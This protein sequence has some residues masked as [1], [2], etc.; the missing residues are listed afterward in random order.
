MGLGRV[1]EI[2][3]E[4]HQ[5]MHAQ[6]EAAT[7]KVAIFAHHRSLAIGKLEKLA[8]RAARYGQSI[9]WTERPFVE[10]IAF[11]DWSGE[12]QT[13]DV[14]RVELSVTGS[15]PKAGEYVFLAQLE[16]M[17]GGVMVSAVTGAEIGQLGYE[18]NGRCDHCGSNRARRVAFVVEGPD[19]RK[20]VGK[21]CLRDHLGTDAPEGLLWQFAQFKELDAASKD[22]EWGGGGY[23][24][25]EST[26]GVIAT[27]RAAIALYGWRPSSHEG[28]TTATYTNLLYSPPSRDSKGRDVHA[29]ERA[30][31]RT[32]LKER[33]DHY[34]AEAE[35]VVDWGRNLTPRGDY[36]HN[37]KVA[38]AGDVVVGKT[39]NLVVSACAAFDRQVAREDEAKRQREAEEAKRASM[40]K[41]NHTGQPGERITHTITVE[42]VIGLPDYGY[43]PST[44]YKLRSDEG[45]VL[46]WKTSSGAPRIDGKPLQQGDRAVVAATVKDH[47]EFRGE[48]ETRVLRAKFTAI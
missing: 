27:A 43:G 41:S 2:F 40:P 9:T 31:L 28:F 36:E 8:K 16:R 38:L 39:F 10:R 26:L 4:E 5:V 44:L 15:A 12:R 37:L 1:A 6:P 29:T 7:C 23:R 47:A 33:G 35:A 11:Y 46:A 20:I 21:S 34:R 22:E 32:D 25:E 48:K 18:W 45:P 30:A 19:G 24:W 17:P 14:H 3:Q 42:A 13:K